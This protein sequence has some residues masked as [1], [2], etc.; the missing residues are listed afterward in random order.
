MI[1]A[2]FIRRPVSC[3]FDLAGPL[4]TSAGW[5]SYPLHSCAC[6]AGSVLER[7]VVRTWRAGSVLERGALERYVV[8]TWRAR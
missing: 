6:L 4:V 1:I 8:R 5:S 2:S 7:Y 3:Q